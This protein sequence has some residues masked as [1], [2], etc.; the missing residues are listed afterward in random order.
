M[1]HL[2]TMVFCIWLAVVYAAILGWHE[3]NMNKYPLTML[4]VGIPF[5]ISLFW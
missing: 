4:V 5:I 2:Y 3:D 1:T